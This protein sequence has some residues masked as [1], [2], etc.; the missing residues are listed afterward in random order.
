MD[1]GYMVIGFLI[2]YFISLI[3]TGIFAS[4]NMA[5]LE[6]FML[7][8]RKL[9]PLV[10]ALTYSS[11]GMSGWLALGF[12]GYTY[13]KGFQSLWIMVP[14]ATIGIFLS[15]VL[16]SKRLRQYSE[17]IGAITITEVIKKRFHDDRNVL[18]FITTLIICAAAIAYVSGQLIAM[19]K[20]LNIVLNWNYQISII[21]AVMIMIIYTVLG[22]FLA[23]CWTDFIQ[24]ILMITGSLMAGCLAIMYAGGFSE[25]SLRL[26]NVS[27]SYPEFTITPFEGTSIIIMGLSL[28]IGDGILNWIGQPTL[29]VR[30][31]A[32][33]DSKTL[34]SATIIT[35]T[36]QLILFLGVFIAAIYMR[37][38][39]PEPSLLPYSG[40]TETVLI[41]FFITITHPILVGIFIGAIMAAV[42]STA[43]SLLMMA[44]SVLIND[45]YSYLNP[46]A[47]Q[48]Y[49]I[50]ISRIT[51][52]FLGIVSVVI[53]LNKNS[54]L[55]LSWFG[56]TT[57]GIIG[58]PIIIGLFWKKTTRIGAIAG[59]VSGF[60]V[61]LLW[62]A[63]D[64]TVRLNIFQALPACGT[65]YLVTFIVSMF[66]APPPPYILQDIKDLGFQK[67]M[68]K[69]E[70]EVHYNNTKN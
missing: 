11:T 34:T 7:A 53:S 2:V 6:D 31:M 64:L 5:N 38:Q 14:S 12:A 68:N 42:M 60:I 39:F 32:A 63:M 27:R 8:G 19:G 10:L 4:K 22:G 47:S 48:S 21:I 52:I 70:V 66:T 59:L 23:V 33:K 16:V 54:V 1:F 65:A 43:D 62:N 24:G 13:E 45:V 15:Y 30:Y 61:L 18:T 25:L 29:M 67:S 58:A 37:T 28:F 17:K 69:G 26:A 40:D 50:L 3:S 57:L 35:I 55:W 44:T 9:D 51:T 20:L 41:Q 46:K 56:W 36:I 49:L